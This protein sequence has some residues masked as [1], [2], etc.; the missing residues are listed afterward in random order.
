MNLSQIEQVA[1]TGA[2]S[3]TKVK[4]IKHDLLLDKLGTNREHIRNQLDEIEFLKAECDRTAEQLDAIRIARDD[5]AKK[6]MPRRYAAN[7]YPSV[8]GI[9]KMIAECLLDAFTCGNSTDEQELKT[10]VALGISLFAKAGSPVY[11]LSKALL[12]AIDHTDMPDDMAFN[13]MQWPHDAM[14]FVLPDGAFKLSNGKSFDFA[15]IGKYPDGS[16]LIDLGSKLKG[17]INVQQE[18]MGVISTGKG[19][20]VHR[21]S[22][23]ELQPA[24]HIMHATVKFTE[25]MKSFQSMPLTTPANYSDKYVAALNNGEVMAI[26]HRLFALCVKLLLL[27]QARPDLVER[28]DSIERPER[29]RKEKLEREALWKPN[30]IGRNYKHETA[31]DRAGSGHDGSSREKRTHIRRGHWTHQVHGKGRALRKLLWIAAC[32]I[33]L[34]A[35]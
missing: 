25:N 26:D 17:G 29:V 33:N 10:G 2:V 12:E 8:K 28:G 30:F 1:L 4:A 27:M 31:T 21:N 16:H 23:G 32:W 6:I 11:F 18:M 20:S 9:G 7:N 14:M 19:T 5:L 15:M 24:Y 13:E 22:L 35:E 34:E 3:S